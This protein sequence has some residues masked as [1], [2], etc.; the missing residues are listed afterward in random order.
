[1]K[2]PETRGAFGR[3]KRFANGPGAVVRSAH[4]DTCDFL[5]LGSDTHKHNLLQY[6]FTPTV[7]TVTADRQNASW[8]TAFISKTDLRTA[9]LVTV[10]GG[11]QC[12]VRIRSDAANRSLL[13]APV[14]LNQYLWLL[15]RTK[16]SIQREAVLNRNLAIAGQLLKSHAHE[17]LTFEMSVVIDAL[18]GC[19]PVRFGEL[20]VYSA[21]RAGMTRP[22]LKVVLSRLLLANQ[23]CMDL[24][25]APWTDYTPMRWGTPG[26]GYTAPLP[27]GMYHEEKAA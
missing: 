7:T 25:S 20:L 23:L 8:L 18:R 19:G 1:M 5:Q 11:A 24:Y 2:I 17:S 9:Q 10:A 21:M 6:L 16:E 4:P 14:R 13:P 15:D 27:K 12:I 22:V 3:V 26:V